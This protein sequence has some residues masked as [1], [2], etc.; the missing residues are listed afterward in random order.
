MFYF[1][2]YGKQRKLTVILEFKVYLF[3]DGYI[4]QKL[5]KNEYKWSEACL[6][7][8]SGCYNY[9]WCNEKNID[10]YH[11]MLKDKEAVENS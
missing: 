5:N 9:H 7:N 6:E 11:Y 3:K 4:S 1:Y 2:H 10:I 8:L